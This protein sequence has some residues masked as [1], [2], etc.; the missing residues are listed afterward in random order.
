MRI[1]FLPLETAGQMVYNTGVYAH[2]YTY[3]EPKHK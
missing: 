3:D 1:L 2:L